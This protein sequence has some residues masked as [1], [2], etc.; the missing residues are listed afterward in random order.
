MSKIE[1]AISGMTCGHCAMTVTKNLVTVEGVTNVQ[2]DHAGGKAIVEV[3]G[4]SNEQLSDAVTEAG[5][6]ATGFTTINE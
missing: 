6:V 4:V 2:V 3:D 5:Y 1:I